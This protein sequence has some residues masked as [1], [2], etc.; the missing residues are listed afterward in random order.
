VNVGSALPVAAGGLAGVVTMSALI[1]GGVVSTAPAIPAP[2]V[3]GS[4]NLPVWGCLGTGSILAV[5]RPNEKMLVTARNVDGRWYQVYVPGP[6][7]QRGWVDAAS[8]ELLADGLGLPIDGCPSLAQ[9]SPA[10][11][12]TTPSANPTV[13]ATA[14]TLDLTTIDPCQIVT[15]A[16]AEELA[17]TPLF[18]GEEETRLMQSHTL[19]GERIVTPLHSG[20]DLLPI[21]RHH[22]EHFGGRGYP[23]GLKET[24]FPCWRGSSPFATHSTPWSMTDPTDRG[25][26]LTMRPKHSSEVPASNGIPMSLSSLFARCAVVLTEESPSQRQQLPLN[27]AVCQQCGGAQSEQKPSCGLMA[28]QGWANYE[29][30]GADAH[31]MSRMPA[32]KLR[33]RSPR[34][35]PMGSPIWPLDTTSRLHSSPESVLALIPP[36]RG[37]RS[38]A[39][40][41]V[42]DVSRIRGTRRTWKDQQDTTAGEIGKGGHWRNGQDTG[43]H[44]IRRVRDREAPGA[45]PAPTSS[46]GPRRSRDTVS[47]ANQYAFS[48]QPPS[49][50]RCR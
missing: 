2:A 14:T 42:T 25:A 12:P 19:I 41:R 4:G 31:K 45:I 26:L 11:T 28:A 39:L 7:G 3:T 35:G 1:A 49:I 8:I 23:D 24:I 29:T 36:M 22:H 18:A 33:C 16:D 48:T 50:S 46:A 32:V 38:V 43:G 40:N 37:F 47:R 44:D 9:S 6:V 10:A 5:A 21:I 34:R 17:R 13:S 20:Q 30:T 27:V 15:N